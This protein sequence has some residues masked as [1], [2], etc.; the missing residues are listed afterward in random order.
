MKTRF[1]FLALAAL[2]FANSASAQ[3]SAQQQVTVEVAEIAVIAVQGNVQMTINQATPGQN[4]DP[5]SAS[6]TYSVSTNGANKKITAQLN[7]NMPTGLTLEA[8]LGA[9]TTGRSR[10]TKTLSRQAV[11]LVTGITR[12]RGNGLSISY[13]ATATVDARPDTYARTVTYTITNN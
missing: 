8:A 9:P 6:A 1:F 4:P 12:V 10:G 2:L 11:D 5:V 3:S 7:R 13:T